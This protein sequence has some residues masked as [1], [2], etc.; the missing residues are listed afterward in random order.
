M[1]MT[2]RNIPANVRREI[3]KR[4][5]ATG[6]SLNQAAIDAWAAAFGL[7]ETAKVLPRDLS[8]MRGTA[9]DVEELEKASR[10]FRKIDWERW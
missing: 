8:F 6:R 7:D 4:A 2:I 1:Q 5:R 3:E 9:E 10:E